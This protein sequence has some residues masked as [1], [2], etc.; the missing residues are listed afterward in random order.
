MF[1]ELV[2]KIRK[3]FFWARAHRNAD[4][5]DSSKNERPGLEDRAFLLLIISKAQKGVILCKLGSHER[6]VD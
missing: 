6:V 3:N 4:S 2:T 5:G 1:I